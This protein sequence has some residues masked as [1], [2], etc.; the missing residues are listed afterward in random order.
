MLGG[1]LRRGSEI[2]AEAVGLDAALADAD[3]VVTGEGRIDSQTVQGKTP[4]G[5]ARVAARHGCPVI[6][7]GGCLANDSAVVHAHG[8]DATLAAVSRACTQAEAL[9]EAESNL[10]RVARN[11]AALL[12]LGMHL[13]PPAS[14]AA[15]AS[16]E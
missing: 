12:R 4:I 3:L 13:T 14:P 2:V 7:I 10:Q 1:T 16:G 11:A 8:L 5:V 15:P 6:A 9:A